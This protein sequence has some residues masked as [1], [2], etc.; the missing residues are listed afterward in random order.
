MTI[1]FIMLGKFL[2][3]VSSNI[4]SGPSSLSSSSEKKSVFNV[5]LEIS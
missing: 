2:I 1:S 5:V 4:F 3:I